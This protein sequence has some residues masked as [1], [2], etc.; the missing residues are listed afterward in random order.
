MLQL[1]EKKRFWDH[2]RVRTAISKLS[3]GK[4]SQIR[5]ANIGIPETNSNL[6]KVLSRLYLV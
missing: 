3:Q 2:C 6:E 5:D 1:L 4:D